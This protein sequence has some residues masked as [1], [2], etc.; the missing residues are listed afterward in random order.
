MAAIPRDGVASSSLARPRS[1]YLTRSR[2]T[3][4]LVGEGFL[5]GLRPP[6]S[7]RLAFERFG[8]SRDVLGRV[9]ATA[10]GDIDQPCPCKV[11][12]I[13]RHVLRPQVEPCFR[14]G[15]RQ[16]SIRVARDRYV[17]LLRELLQE[18]IHEI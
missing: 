5:S 4:N 12:Q 1:R 17:G 13:T 18:R 9:A 16:P 6:L 2:S 7:R 10:A 15:I 3:L 8:D 11:A 14:E